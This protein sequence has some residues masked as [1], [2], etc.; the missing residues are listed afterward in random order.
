MNIKLRPA[1]LSDAPILAEFREAES[2]DGTNRI[3]LEKELIGK[4]MG[5]WSVVIIEKDGVLAGY[6]VFYDEA[7]PV[8]LDSM[9]TTISD[10]YIHPGYNEPGVPEA[11]FRKL[12]DEYLPKQ[13]T[14]TLDISQHDGDAHRFW[15]GMGFRP[16]SVRMVKSDAR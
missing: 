2:F 7:D 12:A 10:F 13:S 1:R 4:I 8:N 15:S 3:I 6:S 14:L 11:I 9:T 5:G 16:S